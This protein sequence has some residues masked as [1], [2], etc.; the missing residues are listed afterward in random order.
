MINSEVEHDIGTHFAVLGN[1]CS[2][3]RVKLINLHSCQL[4]CHFILQN[5]DIHLDVHVYVG[6]L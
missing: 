1:K 2:H 6:C 4:N 3:Q 5:N